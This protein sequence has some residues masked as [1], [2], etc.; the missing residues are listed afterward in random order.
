MITKTIAARSPIFISEKNIVKIEIF[1]SLLNE[2]IKILRMGITANNTDDTF[3]LTARPKTTPVHKIYRVSERFVWRKLT[4]R[5]TRIDI[6]NMS[7]DSVVPKCANWIKTG[8]KINV[9]SAINTLRV[10]FLESNTATF[11]MTNTVKT[12]EIADSARKERT[13]STKSMRKVCV[14]TLAIVV[15]KYP[16]KSGI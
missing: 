13:V 16:I 12:D 15:K 1:F 2:A 5:Y 9:I 3:V 11:V 6:N 7:S 14:Q 4:A 10:A 8:E